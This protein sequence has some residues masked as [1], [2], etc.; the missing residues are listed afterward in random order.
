MK[1]ACFSA[2]TSRNG[3]ARYRAGPLSAS[4]SSG[5]HRA[6]RRYRR[7]NSRTPRGL[8]NPNG[9]SDALCLERETNSAGA[10]RS[11][12]LPDRRSSRTS[13]TR[14][15][16]SGSPM[17]RAMCTCPTRCLG[18]PSTQRTPIQHWGRHVGNLRFLERE[19][20]AAFTDDD[21]EILVLFSSLAS[22]ASIRQ[23]CS[24]SH[25][26][27]VNLSGYSFPTQ[28]R[29]RGILDKMP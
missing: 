6:R 10:S 7:A 9:A 24:V 8:R 19:S 22:C 13:T 27:V 26:V 29:A 25:G 15:V 16:D 28:I 12:A 17:Y 11:T 4:Q 1:I 20:G 23:F 3:S 5:T 14:M 2:R 21:E 18:G